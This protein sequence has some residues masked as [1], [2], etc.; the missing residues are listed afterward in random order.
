MK[1]VDPL[2][3]A[4]QALVQREGGHKIVA[5]EAR[6]SADNLWQILNGTMLPSGNPRGVGPALR[7]KL[8]ARYP[9]WLDAKEGHS[10]EPRPAHAVKP[11]SIVEI[12]QYN[13]GGKMGAGLVLRDQPGMIASWRVTPE[14]IQKNVHNF[15]NARNL[16]IVTGFGDSMR[17]LYNPGDP[18][19]VDRGVTSVEFDGI[20]FFR[21]GDEGFIKRLQRIPGNGLLA[22][23][24]NRSYRDWTVPTENFEVFA[25][26]IKVWRGEEF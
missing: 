4:L 12:P 26:V 7:A 17:P 19:L 24:E 25:R 5:D 20:Y 8:L 16:A 21:V 23:S 1:P 9:D 3:V 6:V 11:D 15:G 18:L 13:T 10:E 2:V 22:I 14:W